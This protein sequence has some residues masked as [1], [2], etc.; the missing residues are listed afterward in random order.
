MSLAGEA[1]WV[2]L[3][4]ERIRLLFACQNRRGATVR[5]L[6]SVNLA[7]LLCDKL[8]RMCLYMLLL[9]LA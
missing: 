4:S 5:L 3:P 2:T 8:H 7:S 1:S 9:L 6:Q